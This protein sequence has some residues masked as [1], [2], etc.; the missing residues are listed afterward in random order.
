MPRQDSE[1]HQQQKQIGENNPFVVKLEHQAWQA[2]ALPEAGKHQLVK[3]DGHKP[4]QRD[5]KRLVVEHRDTQQ[6]EAEQNEINRKAEQEDGLSRIRATCGC[7]GGWI[8]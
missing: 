4:N 7:C 1:T 6:R 5:L 3:R 2:R 8:C